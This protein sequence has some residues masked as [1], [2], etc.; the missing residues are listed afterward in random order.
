MPASRSNIMTNIRARDR[1]GYECRMSLQKGHRGDG[2]ETLVVG[3][4][5]A[6]IHE[7]LSGNAY[8]GN[9]RQYRMKQFG[10]QL[11]VVSWT[12]RNYKHHC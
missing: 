3:V 10:G 5:L 1:R 7:V 9:G 4:F 12:Y 11:E 6:S 8:V 2:V